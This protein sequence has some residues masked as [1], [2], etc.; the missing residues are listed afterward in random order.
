VSAVEFTEWGGTV[1]MAD[2]NDRIDDR[3]RSA[4]ENEKASAWTDPRL[5]VSICSI[6]LTITICLFTYI[7]SQLSSL[8]V[9]TTK[10]DG[11]VVAIEKRAD[12]LESWRR[13]IE[14][15]RRDDDKRFNDYQTMN[16]RLLGEIKGQLERKDKP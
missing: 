8:L 4:R 13:Q 12:D 14:K 15:D 10:T 1:P 9:A 3:G 7:S 5:W 6:L 2:Q 16:A 11:R